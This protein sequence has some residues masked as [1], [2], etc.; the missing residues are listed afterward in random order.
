MS[1]T[2]SIAGQGQ[3]EGASLASD[4]QVGGSQVVPAAPTTTPAAP[5]VVPEAAPQPMPNPQHTLMMQE[6]EQVRA[7][8]QL[9]TTENA[10]RRVGM[11]E[12]TSTL[13]AQVGL[14]T[15]DQESYT[16]RV[17]SMMNENVR[18]QQERLVTEVA[19]ERG[20]SDS[21]LLTLLK[22]ENK[23]PSMFNEATKL[24]MLSTVDVLIDKYPTIK[25]QTSIGGVPSRAKSK[26]LYSMEQLQNLSPEEQSKN[27]KKVF[28]SMAALGF[29]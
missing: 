22:G 14:D 23:L 18:L 4:P 29:N 13:A 2:T 12:L 8:N 15:W 11:N 19:T 17:H 3:A 16:Q 21:L 9:L 26:D 10:K 24:E 7:Q 28:E 5:Q 27:R 1:T 25:P 6:L 20:L